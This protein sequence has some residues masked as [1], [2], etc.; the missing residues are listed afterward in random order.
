MDPTAFEAYRRTPA[1]RAGLLRLLIGSAV[2]AIFWMA[3]T[4]AALV[5]GGYIHAR[6]LASS[7][8]GVPDGGVMRDF[9]TTP[10]GVLTALASFAGI[11][12]GVWV[13]MRLVHRE[14][15]AALIGNSRRVS[16]PSFAKGL[17]AVAITSLLSEIL[18]YLLHPGIERSSIALSSWLLFLAPIVLL[19]LLQTSSEELLF[20]GYLTRGL[21]GRFRSPL[22]WGLVPLLLFT[23]MHWSPASSLAI[24]LSVLLSIFAFALVLLATVYATGNLGAA[25]G[26]H[27]G[28]NLF[29]FLL[30][31]HQ[32]SYDAFALLKA[33]P[34]EAAGWTGT[35][36]L[37]IAATGLA[38]SGLTALLLLHPRSPLRL[39]ADLGKEA[40]E[41]AA[42]QPA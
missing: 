33:S 3:G 14:P 34:L 4:A 35:D 32:Q 1:A 21:A 23:S 36:A 17:A 31:S 30:I 10:T 8:A 41:E 19:A 18:L 24:N 11:W 5:G 2:V 29:G 26:A 42:P 27:L 6:W 12:I 15:L 7:G 40:A 37:L 25:F 22:V 16:W 13:A 28:N 20:R 39:A 9:I 38:A